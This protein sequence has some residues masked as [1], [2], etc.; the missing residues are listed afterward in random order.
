MRESEY[1][2]LRQQIEADYRKRLDALDLVW[3]M[4]GQGN[5]HSTLKGTS[6]SSG[7]SHAVRGIVD[8]LQGEFT[9]SDVEQ[10][11]KAQGSQYAS[12]SR[13]AIAT[14]LG[15]IQSV[16]IISKGKGKIEARYKKR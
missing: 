8:T 9:V 6:K 5:G 15:R 4:A 1:L 12:V 14:T 13:K 16:E 10:P 11:L 7:V 3:K 2:R